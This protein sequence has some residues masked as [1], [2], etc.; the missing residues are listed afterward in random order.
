MTRKLDALARDI[1][2]LLEESEPN[3][4]LWREIRNR[5]WPKYKRRYKDTKGFGVALS[6][7]LR[8]LEYGGFLKQEGDLWGTPESICATDELVLKKQ[9]YSQIRHEMEKIKEDYVSEDVDKAYRRLQILVT[10]VLPEGWKDEIY[11]LMIGY[12]QRMSEID[13]KLKTRSALRSGKLRQEI[14][15]LKKTMVVKVLKELNRLLK[16]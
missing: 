7:K 5:L 3:M 13:A 12:I 6:N 9:K 4:L 1:V 11:P 8:L 2:S 16:T 10:T 14:Q 15:K